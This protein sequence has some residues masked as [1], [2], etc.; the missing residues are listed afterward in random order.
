MRLLLLLFCNV[1]VCRRGGLSETTSRTADA[2]VSPCVAMDFQD[3]LL[4]RDWHP[5]SCTRHVEREHDSR[6]CTNGVRWRSV[7]QKTSLMKRQRTSEQFCVQRGHRPELTKSEFRTHVGNFEAQLLVECS[8]TGATSCPGVWIH[9]KWVLTIYPQDTVC[10]AKKDEDV[11][12]RNERS[13]HHVVKSAAQGYLTVC[14]VCILGTPSI[15]VCCW[16]WFSAKTRKINAL[17]TTRQNVLGIELKQ[18]RC[19]P[20]KLSLHMWMDWPWKWMIQ[21]CPS[22]VSD[23]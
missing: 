19:S 18:Q 3:T 9:F 23:L 1:H 22:D 7:F 10:S 17:Q 21:N 13:V 20:E 14:G 16:S 8:M 2:E 4:V 6:T 11:G 5:S 15:T 12:K